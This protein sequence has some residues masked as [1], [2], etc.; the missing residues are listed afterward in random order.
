MRTPPAP[1]LILGL[2]GLLPFFAGAGVYAFGS[3]ELG[4]PGLLTL[5][6]WSAAVLS[7]LG[8]TRWGVEIAENPDPRWSV[9]T[10]SVLPPLAA[11]LLLAAAPLAQTERQLGGFIAAFA[12]QWLW[13]SRAKDPPRWYGG[14]RTFL[15]AGAVVSL[16][17]ALWATL[18]LSGG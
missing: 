12:L 16:V 11:W 8:G 17:L 5:L 3:P 2:L 1:A 7:F 6:T 9:L 15:T 18:G 13:D 4:G 10:L 14:L